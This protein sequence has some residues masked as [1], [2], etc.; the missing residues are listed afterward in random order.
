[1]VWVLMELRVE[2]KAGYSANKTN[3]VITVVIY[4]G[5]HTG[6]AIRESTFD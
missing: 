6:Y 3:E 1:M 2:W 5:G 4:S